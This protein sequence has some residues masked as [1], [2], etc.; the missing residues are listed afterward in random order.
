MKFARWLLICLLTLAFGTHAHA[1]PTKVT[2]KAYLEPADARA[3][4]GAQ[5]VV[6]AK[7]ADGWHIYSIHPP[8]GIGPKPTS[9][10]L[11]E[12]KSL[13]AAGEAIEPKAKRIRD[14][15]FGIDVDEF[16]GAVAFGIPV[17]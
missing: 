10:E 4:E 14:E 2:W 12:G 17:T 6:E 1:A 7:I 8:K 3:G 15:G 9:F 11:V 16:P 5:V 13:K